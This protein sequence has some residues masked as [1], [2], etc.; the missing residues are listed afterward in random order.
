MIDPPIQ[1]VPNGP[2]LSRIVA[3]Q[4]VLST[5]SLI[6]VDGQQIDLNAVGVTGEA[7]NEFLKQVIARLISDSSKL[8]DV[9]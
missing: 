5:S 7:L 1:L 3:N 4:T 8:I 9:S 6:S 2:L